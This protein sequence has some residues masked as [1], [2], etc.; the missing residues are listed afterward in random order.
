MIRVYIADAMLMER[1]ALRLMLLDLNMEIAGEADNWSTTLAESPICR[2]DM[3]V[4]DWDLLP[5]APRAAL[6]ELRQACPKVLVIILIG[7]LEARPQAALSV[8]ADVFISRGELP[9][10]VAERLRAIAAKIQIG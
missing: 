1:S 6:D 9:E 7:R 5:D 2:A 8:G 10:R 3:L 4:A